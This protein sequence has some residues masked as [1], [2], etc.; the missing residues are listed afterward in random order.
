MRLRMATVSPKANEFLIAKFMIQGD[1][2]AQAAVNVS[3]STGDGGGLLAN[4]NRWR[5]QQLQLPPATERDLAGLPT[6]EIA[7]GKV[8]FLELT[9]K[10]ARSGQPARIVGVVV[11]NGGQTWIYKLMGDPKLVESQKDAFMNFVRT[12]RY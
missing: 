5:V 1:S 6:E 7:G 9:G 2:G 4:V 11:P 10:D 12:A 8:T 3:A